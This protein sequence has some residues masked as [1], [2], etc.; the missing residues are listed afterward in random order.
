MESGLLTLDCVE[1]LLLH[2]YKP[3]S[4]R[5]IGVY[6]LAPAF[7][8]RLAADSAEEVNTIEN[9]NDDL[10][11]NENEIDDLNEN[12]NDDLNEN[13]FNDVDDLNENDELN[14]LHDLNENGVYRDDNGKLVGLE[15][16]REAERRIASDL[17]MDGRFK[18]IGGDNIEGLLISSKLL[19]YNYLEKIFII[20]YSKQVQ[21]QAMYVNVEAFYN[22]A[23]L[24]DYHFIL[25]LQ[26][27]GFIVSITNEDDIQVM[28]SAQIRYKGGVDMCVPF[29]LEILKCANETRKLLSS[30]ALS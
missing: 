21:L 10:N 5:Q 9:E 11:E 4:N 22:F 20:H 15:C 24:I 3:M 17:N 23:R 27:H 8:Q 14:E 7:G 16:V 19:P 2:F 13:E 1:V 28:D 6:N 26:N 12:E 30:A 29:N 18:V 25:F